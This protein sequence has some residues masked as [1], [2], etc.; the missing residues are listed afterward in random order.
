MKKYTCPHC[1]NATISP[2]K[3][4]FAGTPKSKGVICP[5]CGK[6]CTNGMQSAVFHCVVDFI[7]F[8][9]VAVSYIKLPLGKS[10]YTMLGF[11]V[12]GFIL[13]RLFDALFYPLTVSLRKD[14]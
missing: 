9:C 11:L 1:G 7:V 10:F 8:I 13:N 4:A 6:H 2:L 14:L 12:A 5:E 3:K